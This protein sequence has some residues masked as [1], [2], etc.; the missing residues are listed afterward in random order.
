MFEV[1]PSR[2]QLLAAALDA[3][4]LSAASRG[5]SVPPPS[6][7][8]AGFAF[9]TGEWRVRHRKLRQRLAG[10]TDWHEF[11][12]TCRAWEL[13]DGQANVEDNHID[14]PA[15]PYRA[16]AF[17]LRDQRTLS[18][19]IWWFDPRFATVGPPVVGTFVDGVGRFYADDSLNGRP[20]RMRFVWSD[21]G[22]SAARWE[23]AFSADGGA[24]WEVNW[25]M[26]FERIV[27]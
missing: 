25:I 16:A 5:M 14:D 9:Q 19:S 17:R 27:R 3:G 2:R 21:I 23:Q 4:A 18:W 8:G 7:G 24:T 11:G 26:R 20:I 15:G 1:D 12:G 6:M 10:S 13:M 22:A